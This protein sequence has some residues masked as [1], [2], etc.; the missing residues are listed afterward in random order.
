MS[1]YRFTLTQVVEGL[2][3]LCVPRER[4]TGDLQRNAVLWL[5]AVA[6]G[7]PRTS[8]FGFGQRPPRVD[9]RRLAES[10]YLGALGFLVGTRILLA[11]DRGRIQEALNNVLRRRAH[12]VEHSGFADDPLCL[13]G[14][15]L[16]ASWLDDSNGLDVLRSAA[17]EPAPTP[18]LALFL[19]AAKQALVRPMSIDLTNA[20]HLAAVVLAARSSI[21]VVRALFPSLPSADAEQMLIGQLCLA[22]GPQSADIDSMVILVALE[23]ILAKPNSLAMSQASD[24]GGS[25]P[26]QSDWTM[27]ESNL[28]DRLN[29]LLPAQFGE[30][31][32]KL[33][34]PDHYL[35]VGAPQTT[36]AIDVL[37]YLRNEGRLHELTQSFHPSKGPKPD[38][39]VSNGREQ[40]G[41]PAVTGD[42]SSLK[43]LA[44]PSITIRIAPASASDSTR[45]ASAAGA[46]VDV[47][48]VI[49]LKEEFRV[50]YEEIAKSARTIEDGGQH[51]Y[52]FGRSPA[53]V[54]ARYSCVATFVGEM[55]PTFASV[56]AEKMIARQRPT[57]LIMLGIAAGIHSDLRIGDVVV[58]S[59]IDSY[60]EAAKVVEGEAG[61]QFE[62][63][64][65]SFQVDA[66]LLGRVRNLEFS[67]PGAYAAWR[68]GARSALVSMGHDVGTLIDRGVIR[69]APELHEA[70]IASGPVVAASE[71]FTAWVR[72]GDRAYKALEMEGGGV[73][74]S[75][76]LSPTGTKALVIRGISDYGDERKKTLD[77][78]GAGVLRRHAMKV[79][80]SFLWTLLECE[81]LPKID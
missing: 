25:N 29:A 18:I 64:G 72:A 74:T 33:G 81:L 28:L 77:A 43:N 7:E 65:N 73:V 3:R 60:L 57:T 16:L 49:A 9:A 76:H 26:E 47:G 51:Y 66:T 30:L 59:Q 80:M 61:F 11:E 55:G 35:P 27:S 39:S 68:A 31:I 46:A 5:S 69:E 20:G 70:H 36:C 6:D 44:Q 38:R 48:I 52:F 10:S 37:K 58:G 40:Q 1:A 53:D 63:S 34:I 41:S 13:A 23:L 67:R 56:V 4:E 19:A 75:V 50:F 42:R 54:T 62:R 12:T 8:S 2:R 17:E 24:Q 15:I 45:A 21:A 14:L 79:A 22:D 32:F 78:T 71:R